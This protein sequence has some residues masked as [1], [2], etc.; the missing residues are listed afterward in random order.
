[1]QGVGIE[2]MWWGEYIGREETIRSGYGKG[3][4]EENECVKQKKRFVE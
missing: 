3:M 4:G 2:G 1:M